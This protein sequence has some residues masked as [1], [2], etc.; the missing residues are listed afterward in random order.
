MREKY[1]IDRS[2]CNLFIL[3]I[4]YVK[5]ITAWYASSRICTHVVTLFVCVLFVINICFSIVILQVCI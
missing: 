2:T 3:K 4:D 5:L 1:S